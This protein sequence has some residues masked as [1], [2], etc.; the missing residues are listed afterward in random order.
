M[1]DD[2]AIFDYDICRYYL[3]VNDDVAAFD[4]IFL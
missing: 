2:L 1:A 4:C 3:V